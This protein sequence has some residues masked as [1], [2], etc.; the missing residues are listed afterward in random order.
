MRDLNVKLGCVVAIVSF[1]V[2]TACGDDETETP[3]GTGGVTSSG[4]ASASGGAKA[5]GGTPP[6]SGGAGGGPATGGVT[7]TGGAT[8]SSGGTA[9][10]GGASSSG[11]ASS[12]GASSGG[13]SSGG[14]SSGGSSSGGASASGGST[15]TG[16]A[17]AANSCDEYC[18]LQGEKCGFEGQWMN[19]ASRAACMTTC[20]EA[21]AS[22]AGTPGAQTGDTLACRISHLKNIT[23][24]SNSEYKTT[25]CPHSKATPATAP[26]TG[27]S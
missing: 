24:P 25:H 5:S 14:A 4:G 9:T 13:A 27:G 20:S 19:F 3:A 15:G 2:A 6:G 21:L 11:G 26:C 12:G 23:D 16:G 8:T 17:A 10:T 1:A 22:K 7:S 18:N